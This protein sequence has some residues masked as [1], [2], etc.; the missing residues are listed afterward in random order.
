MRA[1][2]VNEKFT[3]K[4][5]PI[6]DLGIGNPEK[7]LFPLLKKELKKYNIDIEW[8]KDYHIGDGFWYFNV[9]FNDEDE[10]TAAQDVQ[11]SYGTD[12]AA[13]AQD[14]DWQGGFVITDEDGEE[15][16]MEYTHD[17]KKVIKT[18]VKEKFGSKAE[19]IKR[20]RVLQK[21]LQKLQN[22]LNVL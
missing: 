9:E 12:E 10:P 7:S 3:E 15:Y 13:A 17:Y 1:R 16:L 4:S 2:V 14:E 8:H 18:L 5:D 21:N 11:M 20:A 22:V 19:V 6:Q